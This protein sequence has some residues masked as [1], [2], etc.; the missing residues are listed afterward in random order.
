MP[1]LKE[2]LALF[3]IALLSVLSVA[4]P[5]AATDRHHQQKSEPVTVTNKA[6]NPVPVSVQGTPNVAVSGTP[7]VIIGN[8][9]PIQVTGIVSGGGGGGGGAA[10]EDG[11]QFSKQTPPGATMLFVMFS[12][13]ELGVAQPG[14]RFVVDF[15][16]AEA[17]VGTG[18]PS[19]DCSLVQVRVDNLNTGREVVRSI[20]KLHANAVSEVWGASTQVKMFADTNHQIVAVP[21]PGCTASSFMVSVVGHYV[22]RPAP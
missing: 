21:F 16:T 7:T 9:T 18:F 22:D 3:L 20:V 6:T 4:S 17:S 13:S 10:P 11:S 2:C 1:T 14:R 5:V 15:L 8:T 12:P 19:G